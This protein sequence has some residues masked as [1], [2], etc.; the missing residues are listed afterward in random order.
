MAPKAL[1]LDPKFPKNQT[2][3]KIKTIP[4]VVDAQKWWILRKIY[5]D[6]TKDQGIV[7]LV[8]RYICE[9][10]KSSKSEVNNFLL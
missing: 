8:Q 5:F 7:N 2:K 9:G 6:F 3:N 1:N 4:N 10:K